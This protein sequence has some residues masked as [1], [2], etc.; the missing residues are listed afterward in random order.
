MMKPFEYG[1]KGLSKHLYRIDEVLS[2]LR[3]SIIT[4]NLTETAFWTLELFESGLTQECLEL[5]ESIW[6][7]HIGFGSFFL[8][9]L[10][11][12]VYEDGDVSEENLIAIACAFA[13][14]KICDSTAFHLLLRGLTLLKP[15]PH[16]KEYLTAQEAILDC[17]ARGKLQEAWQLSRCLTEEELWLLL[18]PLAESVDRN[19]A[20]QHIKELRPCRRESLALAFILVSLDEITWI[21]SQDPVENKIPSEVSQAIAEWNSEKQIR[22]RRAVKPRVEALIYLTAR[23]EQ[24]PYDSS[25]S[26]IQDGLLDALLKSEYWQR[27]LEGFMIQGSTWKSERHKELFYDTYFPQDI[28]DEWSLVDREKSHGRGLGK[29]LEQGRSRFIQLT[30]HYSKSIELWNSTFPATLDC[31]MDWNTLYSDKRQFIPMKPMTKTFSF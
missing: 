31:S 8:L 7:N 24:S 4:H 29:T 12:K 28:P 15:F 17:L 30:L 19:D 21:T 2:S 25:E 16:S 27:I 20:F 3:W 10:I 14:R 13:K 22:K 6:V 26:E 5:L 11:L 9:Q 23:S 18:E 1:S